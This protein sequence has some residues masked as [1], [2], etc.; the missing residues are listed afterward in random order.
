[1]GKICLRCGKKFTNLKSHL[2]KKNIC[3]AKYLDINKE[4]MLADY[5]KYLILF[6]KKSKL[7]NV[8]YVAKYL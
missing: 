5:N 1:M 6:E 3:P 2:N 8:N 4:K 7:V